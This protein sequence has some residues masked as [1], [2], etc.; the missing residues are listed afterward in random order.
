[1]LYL[2]G[3]KLGVLISCLFRELHYLLMN[4]FCYS[5]HSNCNVNMSL[6]PIQCATH[7]YL[8]WKLDIVK[9]PP[10]KSHDHTP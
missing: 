10:G 8:G 7:Q 4:C 1:M 9:P 3:H 2:R 6:L 5:N